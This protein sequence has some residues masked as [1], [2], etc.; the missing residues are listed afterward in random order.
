MKPF[1]TRRYGSAQ[2]IGA[3]ACFVFSVVSLSGCTIPKRLNSVERQRWGKVF[4]LP[5]IEGKGPANRNI[6]LGLEK[7]GA[8]SAIE[9]FDWTTGLPAAYVVNLVTLE[10]NKRQAAALADRIVAYRDLYPD[11]PVVLIGHSGGGGVAVLALEALPPG[12]QIDMAILLAPA[13][14][15]DYDLSTA[16]RRTRNGI[17]NFHSRRDVGFLGVGTTIFGRIDRRHGPSA[18]AVGFKPPE[19]LGE[20]DT[21]LYRERLMQVGWDKS[22]RKFGASGSHFGWV[23]QKFVATYL[24]RLIIAG[25]SRRPPPFR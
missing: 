16:L 20:E 15:P 14:S 8:S 18:G 24:A 22:L 4:I 9:I 25:E 17:V 2:V 11:R 5:G 3:I 1:R 13:I 12:R 21:A 10:R 23:N 19:D 6:A 7:G